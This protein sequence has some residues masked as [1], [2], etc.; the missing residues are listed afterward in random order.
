MLESMRFAYLMAIRDA[1]RLETAVFLKFFRTYEGSELNYQEFR[2][3]Q[4]VNSAISNLLEWDEALKIVRESYAQGVC[5]VELD[6]RF[7][8]TSVTM[9]TA[10]YSEVLANSQ[11]YPLAICA[12]AEAVATRAVRKAVRPVSTVAKNE[13]WFA[14]DR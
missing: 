8:H 7:R 10:V 13:R 14:F 2:Q 1:D 12:A 5:S 11:L 9:P 3:A 6:Y 4:A